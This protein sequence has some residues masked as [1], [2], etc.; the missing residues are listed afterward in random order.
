MFT[1]GSKLL[2]GA[3]VLSVFGT[4]VYGMAIGGPLGTLGLVA[5]SIAFAFLAGINLWVRDSNVSAMDTAG[6]E[7]C[8]AANEPASAS[9]WPVVAGF[10]AAL[11][12]VGLVA[13][14]AITWMAVIVLLVVAVEWMVLSWSERASGDAEY[15]ATI[16][17]RIMHP[18]ELPILG[19]VGLGAII[20]AFSRIMLYKPGNAG[21]FIFA[22]VAAAVVLFGTLVATKRNVGKALVA[23]LCSVGALAILGAGVATA[24]DGAHPIEKHEV[25]GDENTCGVELTEADQ[26]PTRAIAAKSNLAATIILENGKLRAEVTGIN[27]NPSAVTLLRSND[28]FVKFKNLDDGDFR[29]TAYLGDDV[30]GAGTDAEV[31]TKDIVCTQAVTKGGTQFVIVKPVRPSFSATADAPFLFSVPGVETAVLPIEV[32]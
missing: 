17:R 21:M 29:L 1:T 25:I 24:L 26:H 14:F 23:A 7:T 10:G 30:Q 12:P 16:R 11:V 31:T 5:V 3:T 4:I 19:A 8:A 27:G 2:L 18:M 22:G 15:N 28:N 13:G 6:I 32:P 20:F 9:M